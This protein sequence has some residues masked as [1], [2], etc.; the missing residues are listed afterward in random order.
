MALDLQIAAEQ[1]SKT[2]IF[3]FCET[4][5]YDALSAPGGWGSGTGDPNPDIAEIADVGTTKGI[6]IHL[7][8]AGNT[9]SWDD[10]AEI[11]LR[12]WPNTNNQKLVLEAADF[13]LTVFPDGK[14]SVT[15]R[16][17]GEFDYDPGGGVVTE[18]FVAEDTYI[19]YLDKV[20]QCCVEQL[21]VAIPLPSVVEFCENK[22]AKAFNRADI[23]FQRM[24]HAA[25]A[26][27]WVTA[28]ES[29]SLLQEICLAEGVCGCGDS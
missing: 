7:D 27:D 14:C 28:N 12:G 9:Y 5:P 6:V 13:G 10:T 15:A 23:V 18:G 4:P 2:K 19:I 3:L 1:Y 25:D 16:V 26:K 20:V 24:R 22:E 17:S 21:A 11:L 8:I 29:L